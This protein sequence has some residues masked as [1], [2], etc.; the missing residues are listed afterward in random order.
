MQSCKSLEFPCQKCGHDVAFSLFELDQTGAIHCTECGQPYLF[1]DPNLVR[2]IEKFEALC[3]QIHLSQEILGNTS[4]GIDMGKE[5]VKIPFKL[6]LTRL[7]SSLD[8]KVGGNPF[9]V[10]FRFEPLNEINPG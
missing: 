7:K 9:T 1:S 4:I 8:L 3:K 10:S 5:Q 2:Q 6:L